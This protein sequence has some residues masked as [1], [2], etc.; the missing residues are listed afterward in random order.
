MALRRVVRL[1]L[2]SAGRLQMTRPIPL[3]R[4]VPTGSEVGQQGHGPLYQNVSRPDGPSVR[5][6]GL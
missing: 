2:Q 3:V 1:D 5:Q 4:A 6:A